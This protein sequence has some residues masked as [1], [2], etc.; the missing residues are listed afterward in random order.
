MLVSAVWWSRVSQLCLLSRFSHV[1]LSVTLWSVAHQAPLSMGF[2]R[3]ECWS[4][5]PCPP[6]G[7]LPDPGIDHLC[8][9]T[10]ISPP[11]EPPA[12]PSSSHLDHHRA[13][14]WAS[15]SFSRF[16]L[17]LYFWHGS[18]YMSVPISHSPH[19]PLTTLYPHVCSL[20]LHFCPGN[21]SICTIFLDSTCI[22]IY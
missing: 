21:M 5:F 13:A 14:G 9:Y 3:Q 19:P 10:H 17:A 16:P 4:G 20:H 12:A 1:W 15:S 8:I 6:P 7:G 2:S 22:L 18:V 11:P